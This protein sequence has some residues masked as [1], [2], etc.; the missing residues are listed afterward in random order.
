MQAKRRI[1]KNDG[2]K[3]DPKYFEIFLGANWP[4]LA[5]TGLKLAQTTK[6]GCKWSFFIESYILHQILAINLH[7][8][9]KKIPIFSPKIGPTGH[10]K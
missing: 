6:N 3:N 1:V 8:T 9:G 4:K 7:H 2:E 10:T 5:Q